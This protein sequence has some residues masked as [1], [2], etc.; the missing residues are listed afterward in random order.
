LNKHN[1]AIKSFDELLIDFLVQ[2]DVFSK[3]SAD[4]L[5]N[6]EQYAGF[7]ILAVVEML[8]YAVKEDYENARTEINLI[9]IELEYIKPIKGK[10]NSNF[11]NVKKRMQ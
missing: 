5:S 6:R 8:K 9:P 11:A 4:V 7:F 1:R 3:R 2:H 10:L